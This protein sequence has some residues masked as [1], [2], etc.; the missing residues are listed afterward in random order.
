MGTAHKPPQQH[1]RREHRP[2]T[3]GTMAINGVKAVAD[4]GI[5]PGA[6]QFVDGEVKSGLLYAVGGVAARAFLGP[7]GWFAFGVDSLSKSLSGKHIYQHFF[8]GD[9]HVV[10]ERDRD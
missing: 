1:P 9:V 4:L 5:L 3:A 7:I 8:E 2:L 10:H 6:S